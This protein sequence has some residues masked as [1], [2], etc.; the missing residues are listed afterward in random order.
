MHIRKGIWVLLT[1]S[2]QITLNSF[3]TLICIG[4][5]TCVV[6]CSPHPPPSMHASISRLSTDSC[7]LI[8]PNIYTIFLF[9]LSKSIIHRTYQM[10][11]ATLISIFYVGCMTFPNQ[12]ISGQQTTCQMP[13]PI[14]VLP[15]PP[16]SQAMA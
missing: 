7:H 12:G 13:H 8:I 11:M 4:R 5:D 6:S 14:L 16:Q 1:V 2:C 15:S 10:T 3:Q 9:S